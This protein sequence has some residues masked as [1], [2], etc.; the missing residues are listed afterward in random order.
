[1][2]T[3]TTYRHPED[4]TPLFSWENILIWSAIGLFCL[5]DF[6]A[7]CALYLEVQRWLWG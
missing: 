1:M 6:I 4:P 3:Y 7:Y 5:I 2:F